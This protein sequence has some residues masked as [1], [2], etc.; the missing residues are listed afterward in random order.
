MS[1]KI[2]GNSAL[3]KSVKEL[4]GSKLEVEGDP[5]KYREALAKLVPAL[6]GAKGIAQRSPL[7]A[8]YDFVVDLQQPLHVTL[9]AEDSP[10]TQ[11]DFDQTGICSAKCEDKLRLKITCKASEIE[12]TRQWIEM[13]SAHQ[14]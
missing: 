9:I 10:P 6:G 14:D 12:T 7:D 8:L 5:A 1:T 13:V 3:I 4:V 11:L 2:K